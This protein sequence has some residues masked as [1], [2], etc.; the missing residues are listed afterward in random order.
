MT[1]KADAA[2]HNSTSSELQP[3]RRLHIAHLD[4]IRALTAIFVV[5]HHAW[6]TVWPVNHRVI[7]ALT[8]QYTGFLAFGNLAVSVF[9][10]ISGFCLMLP[11]IQNNGKLREGTVRFYQRRA[12]RILPPYYAALVLSWALMK[13]FIHRQTGTL[14]DS[15]A[16]LRATGYIGNLLLLQDIIGKGQINYVFW[17][18]AVEFQIYL[19]FPLL[20]RVNSRLGITRTTLI[21]LLFSLA[22]FAI[23]NNTKLAGITPQYY[24][25]FC[26][27]MFAAAIG[28]GSLYAARYKRGWIGLGCF[29]AVVL[30][31]LT[32]HW[33]I[34]RSY[35]SPLPDYLIG[36]CAAFLLIGAVSSTDRLWV[37][38]LG[39]RPLTWVGTFSYSLYLI[40]A[41]LL[42]IIWQYG[43]YPLHLTHE[44]TFALLALPGTAV[45]ILCSYIF[46]QVCERHFLRLPVGKLQQT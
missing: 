27:G 42:Q 2:T 32:Q 6:L 8:L 19:W 7:S 31:V 40:H 39:L 17:S 1:I 4:G 22:G 14:W 25:L 30:A 9:I 21:V 13:L 10:V 16:S 26:L 12:F 45:I 37:R 5:M 23:L 36:I 15:C 33:G 35:H 11:V 28:Y 41:P 18:V 38:W 44:M 3:R 24:G 29:C 46:Y 43:L 20:V 34:E